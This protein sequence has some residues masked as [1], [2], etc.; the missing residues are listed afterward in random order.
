[1]KKTIPISIVDNAQ[2]KVTE[3]V[4]SSKDWVMAKSMQAFA[5]TSPQKN[6]FNV[7]IVNSD[8]KTKLALLL[9]P[10]WGVYFPPYNM[11]R[12]VAVARSAGYHT[13]PFDLNIECY[14]KIRSQMDIDPWDPSKEFLWEKRL[15]YYRQIHKFCEP[16]YNEF[17]EK[18]VD[19]KPDVVGFTLY[20]TNEEPT[21]WVANKLKERLPNT[22]FIVGGP[23]ANAPKESTLNFFDHIVQ[24]EGEK[25]LLEILDSVE[26]GRPIVEKILVQPKTERLNL[27]QLPFPDYTDY[28]LNKY[29]MPNGTSSEISR[30][31][32]AKCVFCTEVHFWKYRGRQAGTI[33]DEVEYQHKKHGIDFVW[34]IDSLVNGNLNEL[35]AFALGVV[36]RNL[37]IKWQGYARCDARMDLSYLQ[38]LAA[39]GCHML[40]FGIESGSQKVL[41]EMKKNIT[42]ETVE[43]NLR[44]CSTVGI[45]SNVNWIIG[46]PSE[47]HQDFSDSL[48]L[49]YRIRNY[50]IINISP[51]ISLMLS[52]GS[53]ISTNTNKFG[54]SERSFLGSW[55]TTDLQNTKLHR[56]IR[57]K[58]FQIFCQHLNP[59]QKT[60]GIDRPTLLKMYSSNYMKSNQ[61]DT[62]DYETFNYNIIKTN[63][64]DFADS[65][66]N[67]KWV[68][69]RNLWKAVGP[70]Q[71]EI[72][73]DPAED[74]KEWGFRLACDYT[75]NY[76]FIIDNHGDWTANFVCKFVQDES[77]NA[78]GWDNYSFEH[79]WQGHG[80]WKNSI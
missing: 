70:L 1:M 47:K 26:Q 56:M 45:S 14:A 75:A 21:S 41:N 69:L 73:Y 48:T 62:I 42:R 22:K 46:F 72:R 6:L 51:G 68:L 30:G 16:I 9:L 27:D 38:D 24:G 2:E 25:L 23:Q 79:V 3:E 34:F 67:E 39:S 8:R 80:N 74:L 55:C 18:I 78:V 10:E 52:P 49:L 32:V 37:K 50:K 76:Q 11:A 28:D 66:I 58:S 13:F 12:L 20:Y 15:T 40:N 44:D 63:I 54:I 57:Q 71:I 53:E 60:W 33:L 64:S 65:V 36:E 61:K 59:K 29:T 19:I 5:R 17:I 7:P 77:S 35:R 4:G 43:H 31:C